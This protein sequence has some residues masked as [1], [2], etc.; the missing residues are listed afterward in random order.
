MN[1]PL[2]S[3]I[4]TNYNYALYLSD[5]IKSVLNQSYQNFEIIIV[6]DGS[7]DESATVLEKYEAE[8]PIKIQ[9]VYK[10]MVAKVLHLIQDLS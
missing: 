6:D 10:K 5:A 7:K 1:K 3:V 9:V 2:V 8:Y 4:I